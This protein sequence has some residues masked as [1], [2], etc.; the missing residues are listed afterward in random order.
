MHH[1]TDQDGYNGIM[2]GGTDVVLW[3]RDGGE[4]TDVI[5]RTVHRYW[6]NFVLENLDDEA[7]FVPRRRDELPNPS[8]P[9]FFLYRDEQS[10]LSWEEHGATPENCNMMLHVIV[11]NRAN[12]G[13]DLK[14]LTVVC[15]ELTGQVGQ[16]IDEVRTGL[17]D[18]NNLRDCSPERQEWAC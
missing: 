11:G 17:D 13:S 10:A 9:E 3:A 7:P 18:L 5:L 14:S 4:A 15:G 1:Y 16:L 2:I 6:P 12:P 8:G